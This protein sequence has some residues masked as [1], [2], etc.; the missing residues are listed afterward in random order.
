MKTLKTIGR[1]ASA[2]S[3]QFRTGA[4]SMHDRRAPRGGACN[5][6]RELMDS[7]MEDRE[8]QGELDSMVDEG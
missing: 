2:V 5:D 6:V 7:Y 1:S 3:A 8:V 4:G